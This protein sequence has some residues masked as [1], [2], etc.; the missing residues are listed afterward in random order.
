M[1]QQPDLRRRHLHR[2]H[3][4]SAGHR[5]GACTFIVVALAACSG[6]RDSTSSVDAAAAV[7]DDRQAAPAAPLAQA[8]LE[9]DLTALSLDDGGRPRFLRAVRPLAAPPGATPEVAAR[10]FVDQLTPVWGVRTPAD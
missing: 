1:L 7:A 10:A 9:R 5:L 6:G 2:V 4:L 8:A 3:S